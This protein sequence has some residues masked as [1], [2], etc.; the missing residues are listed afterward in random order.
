MRK[1]VPGKQGI[2]QTTF[3]MVKCELGKAYDV[4]HAEMLPARRR[5]SV[6]VY[7]LAWDRPISRVKRT[8]GDDPGMSPFDRFC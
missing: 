6:G 3:V 4:G 2:M 1:V 5:R 7:W 8:S